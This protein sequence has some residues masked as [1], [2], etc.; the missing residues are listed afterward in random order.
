MLGN[1]KDKFG[2]YRVGDFRTYSKVEAIELH[3]RTGI[4]PHWD[5]NELY[6]SAYNWQI[7]PTESL[8]ELYARRAL[9]IRADYDY[10]VLFY[11][12]GADSSNILDTFV[13]NNIAIDEVAT[14]NYLSAD[15]DPTNFFNSE[16]VNVSYP[17]LKLLAAQGVKFKHRVIDLS[18]VASKI[19][20]ND[21][22]KTNRAYYASAHWGTSH[23]SKSYIRETTPDYQKLIEQG[24]KVVFVWGCDKPRLY[25][26]NNRYC[27]KF[28]DVIDAGLSSRT[29]IV[30]R[31]YEY[32]ELFYW[33]PETADIVCK[34]AHILKRFFEKHKIY[35]QDKYYSDTLID[36]PDIEQIFA[37]KHT[38]DGL[39]YRNLINTLIYPK[40]SAKTFSAGKPISVVS[41]YR[42]IVWNKDSWYQTQLT[43][44]KGHLVQLDPYWLNDPTD[45]EKG[46]KCS[47]SPAYYLE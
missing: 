30:N 45:I 11:S 34:Q 13:D 43:M 17:R 35:K 7:E 18:D 42:D 37:N 10:V 39:S 15:S 22:Y 26:E 32:D 12:G 38:E 33:A 25:Q 8:E 23:L 36:L 28:L 29:Q 27:I 5:F 44:L 41:S 20:S 9:Q 16:Q 1:N 4:H 47:I 24:K 40:F 21:H 6:F 46:L 31:D 19:L 3:K 14:F 2:Y